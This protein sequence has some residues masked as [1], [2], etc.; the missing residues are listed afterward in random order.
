MTLY[1][2]V[3]LNSILIYVS[4]QD[5]LAA[6]RH[7]LREKEE[8]IAALRCKL[9]ECNL[10]FINDDEKLSILE[11]ERSFERNSF[12]NEIIILEGDIS[13][14]NREI[15]TILDD[16]NKVQKQLV[17]NHSNIL[18]CDLILND[19]ITLLNAQ[20]NNFKAENQSLKIE[21]VNLKI[22]NE[23]L[24]VE[25]QNLKNIFGIQTSNLKVE[26]D[27]L[28]SEL[29]HMNLTATNDTIRLDE[30]LKLAINSKEN[31]EK[32]LIIAN[33]LIEINALTIQSFLN[34]QKLSD[35]NHEKEIEALHE[36]SSL[37]HSNF[38]SMLNEL[39]GNNEEV[40]RNQDSHISDLEKEI[41][42]LNEKLNIFKATDK[43]Q[44]SDVSN[45]EEKILMKDSKLELMH[46]KIC[47]NEANLELLVGEI[48]GGDRQLSKQKEQCEVLN[49]EIIRQN[50]LIY[51]QEKKIEGLETSKLVNSIHICAHHCISQDVHI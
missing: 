10:Q 49:T 40:K 36:T 25:K 5:S 33:E 12:Q 51:E 14:L 22:E 20:N 38:Q 1:L 3:R 18:H 27:T 9:S 13:I 50:T 35:T 48:E 43:T 45:L 17:N 6:C 44:A 34:A 46:A 29:N 4:Q 26:N 30:E 23:N 21:N 24:K 16:G 32:E 2:Y 28:A 42:L 7:L 31:I 37:S 8:V 47:E 11:H 39:S 41:L 19:K 15:I